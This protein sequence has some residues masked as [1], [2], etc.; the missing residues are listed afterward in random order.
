MSENSK[1]R[2][3][4]KG[5]NLP[6]TTPASPLSPGR[7]VIRYWPWPSGICDKCSSKFWYS[8]TFQAFPETFYATNCHWLPS[9]KG[10]FCFWG[11]CNNVVRLEKI[12]G[13]W[14][15]IASSAAYHGWVCHAGV[16]IRRRDWSLLT[17][18]NTFPIKQNWGNA[19]RKG[20]SKSAEG[21]L[22]HSCLGPDPRTCILVTDGW[23]GKQIALIFTN[24][25][26]ILGFNF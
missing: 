9:C 10:C 8:L 15:D 12:M 20:F 11:P 5:F 18:A 14:T 25:E 21:N 6:F 26:N 7:L 13:C 22:L 19:Y 1:F 17:L 23:V 3:Y 2:L 24:W 16:M 4:C